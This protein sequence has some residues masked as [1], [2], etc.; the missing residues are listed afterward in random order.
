MLNAHRVYVCTT[1]GEPTAYY[2]HSPDPDRLPAL[3]VQ[4]DLTM[5]VEGGLSIMLVVGSTPV[6]YASGLQGVFFCTGGFRGPQIDCATPFTLDGAI[7]GNPVSLVGPGTLMRHDPNLNLNPVV[8]L[9]RA[10]LRLVTGTT[11]EN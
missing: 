2:H 6:L 9:T 1:L 7:L 11:Q 4:G 3:L 5:R 8:E 10:G